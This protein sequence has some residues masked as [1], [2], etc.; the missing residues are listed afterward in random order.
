MALLGAGGAGP[1]PMVPPP[2]WLTPP[3]SGPGG[4]AAEASPPPLFCGMGGP[5]SAPITPYEGEGPQK[6]HLPPPPPPKPLLPEEGNWVHSP[7][8]IVCPLRFKS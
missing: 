2:T 7:E 1:P 8:I 3:R 5:G 4:T 6:L